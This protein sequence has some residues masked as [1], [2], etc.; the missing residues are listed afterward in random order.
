[1]YVGVHIKEFI[2]L[3]ITNIGNNV[4]YSELQVVKF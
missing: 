4:P 1:M 3:E 2:Q